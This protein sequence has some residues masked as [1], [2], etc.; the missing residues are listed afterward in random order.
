MSIFLH[1][2]YMHLVMNSFVMMWLGFM[3]E[4]K[5]GSVRYI[6]LFLLSG[7]GGFMFSSLLNDS[8]CVGAS[9]SL[10]GLL[11]VLMISIIL[12]WE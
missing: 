2:H 4:S 8:I 6:C 10:F 1:Q 11:G 5:I 9:C 7:V 12:Y 3:I